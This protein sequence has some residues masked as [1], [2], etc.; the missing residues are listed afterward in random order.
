LTINQLGQ[1]ITIAIVSGSPIFFK[2]I[3]NLIHF[4]T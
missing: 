3:T 2:I 1:A 4:L